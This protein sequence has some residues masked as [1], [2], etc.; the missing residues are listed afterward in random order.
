[1]DRT[2]H[3]GVK[4]HKSHEPVCVCVCKGMCV[5]VRGGGKGES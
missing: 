2:E 1:M 4:S 5:F 3:A